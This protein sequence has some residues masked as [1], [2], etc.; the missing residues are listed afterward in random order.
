MKKGLIVTLIFLLASVMSLQP[1][2]AVDRGEVSTKAGG[3]EDMSLRLSSSA[4]GHEQLIPRKYTCDGDDISPPLEWTNAPDG[5]RSFALICDDPDAPAGTW[6]H[7]I[8]YNIPADY[9]ELS[10]SIKTGRDIDSG[11]NQGTNSWGKIE[12]GGPCP[13]SDT[14]RYFFRLYALDTKLDLEGL[15][16]K[17]R[18]LKEMEGHILDESEF[19]GKYTREN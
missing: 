12:Y 15:V 13:P 3:S 17:E 19:M 2:R 11:I 16:D 7:W 9:R 6:I 14:H 4:F 8:I 1:V 10:D 18:L 5:T